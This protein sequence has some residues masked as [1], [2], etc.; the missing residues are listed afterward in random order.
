MQDE[1]VVIDCGAN[2][3]EWTREVRQRL[4]SDRGKWVALEP[5]PS[6]ATILERM[7]NLE[8]I[9]A[10]VGEQPG[11]ATL[12]SNQSGSGL[13]SLHERRDTLAQGQEFTL[14]SVEIVTLD[15]VIAQRRLNRVDF[16]KMD[17]EG[18]E[19][20]ALK[21]MTNALGRGVVRALSFEFGTSNVN[22]RTF[23]RDFWELLTPLGFELK[24]ICPGGV[25]MP[26]KEYYEDLE[27]FR[28]VSNY[29]GIL[30]NP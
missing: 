12:Y 4:G 8:V 19:L 27:F 6:C 9:Q 24:R 30:K 15:S 5:D 1:P 22:S 28:G 14:W 18:H 16:L 29:I 3:G 10:A 11:L 17:I 23:F 2:Y 20:F 26:I 21:G 7:D 25:I 13:A